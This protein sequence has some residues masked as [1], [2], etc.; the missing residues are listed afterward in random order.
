MKK[1]LLWLPW[2]ILSLIFV[3]CQKPLK[4]ETSSPTSNVP[5]VPTITALDQTPSLILEQGATLSER[6]AAPNG[7]QRSPASENSLTSFVR[8][9]KLKPHQ[10]PVLLYNGQPKGNQSAHI[11]VFDLDVGQEDLQQCADSVM[12]VYCE[13]FWATGQQERI[14]FH[15]TN[16]FL[17]D[18][19]SYRNGN[20]LHLSG[21]TAS[22]IKNAGYDDSYETFR[23]YFRLIMS[24]AGTLSLEK[25]SQ[26]IESK[27]I[28]TGDLL[29]RGGSPGHCVM[30]V[31]TAKNTEGDIA[32]LLAQ[33]YMPAQEFH[34]L[35][36]PAHPKDPWYYLS[37]LQYPLRT[38]EYSFSDGS[39]KRWDGLRDESTSE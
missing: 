34:L 3:A 2:I 24:Y 39:L 9:M 20:R 25:E 26:P 6:I 16:G 15:L 35:K 29:I 11:A 38:P 10:S 32:F 4:E 5:K 36:N 1:Q 28:K 27:D 22:W 13:Y 19:P 31:D 18:Y 30:V 8:N 37:E 21:N 33:S 7:Y 23:K 12:R 17:M 14:R